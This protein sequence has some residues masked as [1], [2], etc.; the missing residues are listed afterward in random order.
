MPF[1]SHYYLLHQLFDFSPLFPPPALLLARAS[2]I[3][4]VCSRIPLP[5]LANIPGPSIFCLALVSIVFR[6]CSH[7]W[8]AEDFLWSLSAFFLWNLFW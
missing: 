8:V 2:A 5:N 3:L 7:R 6:L 4:F 1:L